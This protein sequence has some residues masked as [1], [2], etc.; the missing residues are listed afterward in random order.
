MQIDNDDIGTARVVRPHGRIDSS[1]SGALEQA[2]KAEGGP[3]TLLDM[4]D[5][6][7]ISSAGLRVV[8]VATKAARAGGGRFAVFGLS[9]SVRSVFELS[10]F[11]RIVSIADTQDGALASPPA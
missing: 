11:D 2:L 7:Y 8:L 5:V 3:V 9:P 4:S 1:T 6:S 10:G